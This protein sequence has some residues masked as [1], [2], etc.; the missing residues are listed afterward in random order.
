MGAPLYLI[1]NNYKKFLIYICAFL[2]VMAFFDLYRGYQAGI[3]RGYDSKFSQDN[4]L[5]VF[6]YGVCGV[7]SVEKM[8]RGRYI[9]DPDALK[10]L[11]RHG[12]SDKDEVLNKF[13]LTAAQVRDDASLLDG[14]L[15]EVESLPHRKGGFDAI[16]LGWGADAGYMDF[17]EASFLVFGWRTN[18]IYNFVFLYLFLSSAI[19][20]FQFYDKIVPLACLVFFNLAIYHFFATGLARDI[21]LVTPMNGRFVAVLAFSPALHAFFAIAERVRPKA[22][23]VGL[24]VVQSALLFL[25]VNARST[26]FSAVISLIGIGILVVAY[27]MVMRR[28]GR[29]IVKLLWPISLTVG[30]VFGLYLGSMVA[31]DSQLS[32]EGQTRHHSIWAST[33][34]NLQLHPDWKKKYALKHGNQS[35]D[36]PAMYA[37]RKY[38]KT[39][40]ISDPL[41]HEVIDRDLRRA[42]I[43]FVIND[44]AYVFELVFY[45]NSKFIFGSS[46][47]PA[48]KKSFRMMNN[49]DVL[50]MIVLVLSLSVVS[51]RK[52]SF[53]S[54]SSKLGG[55]IIF[56]L[57]ASLP[58]WLVLLIVSALSEPLILVITTAHALTILAMVGVVV[59]TRHLMMVGRREWCRRQVLR[60]PAP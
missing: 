26:G 11:E 15:G 24:V 49:I 20:V 22:Y 48:V 54:I 19:F 13:G 1:M 38:R 6:V 21:G 37:M 2:I 44:P 47:W 4:S 59:S 34:Y 53:F 25:V 30:I 45:Y 31:Q 10:L 43:D 17:V 55:L 39:H 5:S 23:S 8:G 7:V 41:T 14:G 40:G 58:T 12:V 33:Y 16:A 56:T 46:M 9:C 28:R 18:S 3:L 51:L 50:V 32:G 27:A 35:G 57:A 42:Y 29:F 60:E 52:K 36:G